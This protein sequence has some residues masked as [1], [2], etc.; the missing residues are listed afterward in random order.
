MFLD[1]P[2]TGSRK[3][4][5]G[6]RHSDDMY[7]T[8]L[9]TFPGG[10]GMGVKNLRNH[11]ETM[12]NAS[13]HISLTHLS[14]PLR[15]IYFP[16]EC[17]KARESKP[18]SSRI[19]FLKEMCAGERRGVDSHHIIGQ[20]K[21]TCITC[22]PG[23]ENPETRTCTFWAVHPLQICMLR[24][25]DNIPPIPILTVHPSRPLS[26]PKK[27]CLSLFIIR[28]PKTHSFCEGMLI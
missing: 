12:G 27:C 13:Q 14:L 26:A 25:D 10:N 1:S 16:N 7:P 28:S 15:K 5:T 19:R 4:M 18:P 20:A 3:C 9:H 11:G 24:P 17:M 8:P 23:N 2:A 21:R 6:S 22:F